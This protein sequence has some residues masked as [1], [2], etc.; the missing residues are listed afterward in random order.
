MAALTAEP[1]IE[2]AS[3]SSH[4]GGGGSGGGGGGYCTGENSRVSPS[5][6]PFYARPPSLSPQARMPPVAAD[7]PNAPRPSSLRFRSGRACSHPAMQS[8][9]D[10]YCEHSHAMLSD[11]MQ[12]L[13]GML[14]QK[15]F[16]PL[17]RELE[18]RKEISKALA[19]RRKVRLDYDA[20]RR[21]QLHLQQSDP[22]NGAVYANNLENAK[23]T[24][25]RH[26]QSVAKDL[27]AVSS[28]RDAALCE[29]FMAFLLTQA[30]FYG[31][32]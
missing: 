28:E 15:L 12:L 26:S 20:Y 23:V 30:D 27:S 2:K 22:D 7:A 24:F 13:A 1:P 4:G 11:N 19:D 31:S 16:K 10:Q 5:S 32:M 17:H 14:N 8:V 3:S 21:K 25:E 6:P 9:A 18:G 29:A